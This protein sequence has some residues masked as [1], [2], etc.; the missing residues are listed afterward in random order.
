MRTYERKTQRGTTSVELIQKAADAVIKDGRPLKTVARELEICHT[1]LQRFVKKLK[2]GETPT[3]GYKP[4]LVFDSDQET[5]LT[6][7]I[8]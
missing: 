8:K 3:N 6:S 4:R 2:A 7:Y 1:T 5:V